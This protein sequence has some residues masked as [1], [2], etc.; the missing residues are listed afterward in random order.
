MRELVI[1]S[2]KGGAGKT[3]IA[4]AV[5][6]AMT[7]AVIADCDVDAADLHLLL[8]PEETAEEV[9]FSGWEPVVADTCMGCGRCTQWCRFAAITVQS[10]RAVV[11]RLTC[12]GC[13]VCSDHCPA[14][15]VTLRERRCG[16]LFVSRTV[17]GTLVH[18]R[19][20]A[21]GENSGKLVSAVRKRARELAEAQKAR[22]IIVDGPPGTGCPVIASLAGADAALLV[23]EPSV[24][25]MHDIERVI[26]LCRHFQVPAWGCINKSD[27]HPG[28]A[29]KVK[30]LFEAHRVGLLGTL[31]YN[32]AFVDAQLERKPVTVLSEQAREEINTLVKE[33]FHDG[34]KD[35]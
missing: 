3:S 2:G 18:A 16:K 17:Y 20:D 7:H 31:G 28:V 11:D 22:F 10:G 25:S 19:L 14:G 13:G 5:A 23:A 33:L 4:A 8:P 6:A 32:R 27:V 15:A 12:E 21:G 1:I 24:S 30:N 29:E 26:R 35:R 9:F 34:K